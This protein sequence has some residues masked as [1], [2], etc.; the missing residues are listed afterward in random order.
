VTALS[1][2]PNHAMI[3]LPDTRHP[4]YLDQPELWHKLLYNFLKAI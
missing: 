4:A 3:T 1:F 2:L